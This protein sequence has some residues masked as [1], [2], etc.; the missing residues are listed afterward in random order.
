[1]ALGGCAN[2]TF[3]AQGVPDAS[4]AGDAAQTDAAMPDAGRS[5]GGLP[6]NAIRCGKSTCTPPGD[7]CCLPE[8]SDAGSLAAVFKN[9]DGT[10]VQADTCLQ[11]SIALR[12]TTPSFCARQKPGTVC[13]LSHLNDRF[14]TTD[15]VDVAGCDSTGPQDILCDPG[16]N[17]CPPAY[18]KCSTAEFTVRFDVFGI[19]V[20]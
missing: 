8:T 19:C 17:N 13:C 16:A 20:Q 3:V 18:A 15:C 7:A 1:V 10:C 5:D 12:C 9:Q 14:T 4:E 6:P 2:E 11:P